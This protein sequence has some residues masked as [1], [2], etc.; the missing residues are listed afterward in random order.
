MEAQ[1]NILVSEELV[2]GIPLVFCR[3]AGNE[4]KQ[5]IFLFHRLLQSKIFELPLAYQL[6]RHNYCVIGMDIRGHG[7]RNDSFDVCGKYDFNNYFTD[8]V[9]TALDVKQ[10]VR[11]LQEKSWP[12][13][14]LTNTGA[15]G[16]SMGGMIALAAGYLLEEVKYVVSIV[17]G[18]DWERI[19]EKSS[20]QSFRL[21]SRTREVF[22]P[23]L[24]RSVIKEYNPSRHIAEYSLKPILFLNG[25]LDFVTPMQEV[26]RFFQ[27]LVEHYQQF[28]CAERVKLIKYPKGGHELTMEMIRDLLLWLKKEEHYAN[29]TCDYPWR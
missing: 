16:I 12:E 14:D 23:K 15:I 10:V 6:A 26:E 25:E 4:R 20:F 24:A 1:K 7:Q 8:I 17:S 3:Q 9:E 27:Q 11:F 29:C 5:V 18:F 13:L 28:N 21:Y 22:D 2:A 19:L